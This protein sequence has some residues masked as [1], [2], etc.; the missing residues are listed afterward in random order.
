MPTGYTA[1]IAD[2]ITFEDFAMRCSRAMGALVMMREE[3]MDA[4][5]PD[6]FEP[7]DYH[8]NRLKKLQEEL[9]W[10]EQMPIEEAERERL[11][12]FEESV[13]AQNVRIK[14]ANDLRAKYELMR[15]AV[16]AWVPPTPEHEGFRDFMLGQIDESIKFDCNTSYYTEPELYGARGWLDI[17]ILKARRDID[18]H[19][20]GHKEEIERTEKR[21]EWLRQLRESLRMAPL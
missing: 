15:R 17:K 6:R 8:A 13:A 12:E 7:S 20:T 1:A 2:G 14:S 18:Y 11:K 5:I 4:P 21:N 16:S 10:L 3:P 9:A 19:T